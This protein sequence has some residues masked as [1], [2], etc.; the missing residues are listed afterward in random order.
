V[1]KIFFRVY[2]KITMYPCRGFLAELIPGVF[3]VQYIIDMSIVINEFKI[4][5]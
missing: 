1:A 3:L 4:Y 2:W 5:I